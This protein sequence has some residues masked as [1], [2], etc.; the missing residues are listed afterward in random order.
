MYILKGMER[1]TDQTLKKHKRSDSGMYKKN[2]QKCD[3]HSIASRLMCMHAREY[4]YCVNN[5]CVHEYNKFCTHY[6]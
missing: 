6:A 3:Y 1:K 2:M 4:H 5:E